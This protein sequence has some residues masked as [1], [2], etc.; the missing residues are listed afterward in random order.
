MMLNHV[1]GVFKS[2]RDIKFRKKFF[3][4]C[5]II[6]MIPALILGFFAYSQINELLTER[7][8]ANMRSR[9]SQ[10]SSSVAQRLKTYE[11]VGEYI[12]W[13]SELRK[14]LSSVYATNSAMYETYTQNIEPFLDSVQYLSPG[15]EDIIL[16]TNASIYPRTGVLE[17]LENVAAKPW[18]SESLRRTASARFFWDNGKLLMT[19]T[20]PELSNGISA[21]AC[22]TI[23]HKTL[24]A[25]LTA[26]FDSHYG[27]LVT[28]ADGSPI[29]SYTTAD[30]PACDINDPLS[31]STSKAYI[32]E[33]IHGAMDWVF[34]LYRPTRYIVAATGTILYTVL[35]VLLCCL[36]FILI[37]SYWF[38]SALVRPLE[39]LADKLHRVGKGEYVE[40]QS[41]PSQDEVGQLV[42]SYT[43]MVHKI[44]LLVNDTLKAKIVRQKLELRALQAQINPHFL[45]N[46]LSLINS[47]AILA[48]QPE[49][50]LLARYLTTF[51]RTSLNKGK[52]I[53]AVRDEIENARAY[54]NIQLIMHSDSFDVIYDI[55][56]SVLDCTM[57]NLMLQ[58][59]IENAIFHGI[60]PLPT[61][62]RGKL[63][64]SV[65][66]KTDKIV[67][68]I[69]DNGS[70]IPE[71]TLKTLLSSRTGGYGAENVHTRA[72]LQYGAGYGLSYSSDS[73]G[74]CARLTIPKTAE[75]NGED[76]KS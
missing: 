7:E 19:D 26:L 32:T 53:I 64:I 4:I 39:T 60:E 28:E 27:V 10:E 62:Q 48:D 13:N 58:P 68:L 46:T 14:T 57:P 1:S 29:F 37:C 20:F 49:I 61:E 17:P 9:I 12:T 15:L 31:F 72:V 56:E 5:V 3:L 38:S 73:K 25:D 41:S 16:Y 44:N 52:D 35:I 23:S 69:Q 18:Y 21:F 45:Y 51:Y 24:F 74:T 34:Y 42:N 11:T 55:D 70:G 65:K 8:R 75:T 36:A 22:L 47:Q 66:D 2:I 63:C 50:S 76:S 6:S 71:E 67:F 59:L 30:F 54:I 33:T 43:D 40:M